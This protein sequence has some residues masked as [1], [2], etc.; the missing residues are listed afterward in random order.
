MVIIDNIPTGI[1]TS[2]IRVN[3]IGGDNAT[4]QSV[5][6][7][8]GESNSSDNPVRV[9]ILEAIDALRDQLTL[10]DDDLTA[11]A[12]QREFIGNLVDEGPAGFAQLLGGQ[13]G[14]IDQ[15]QTAWRAIGAGIAEVQAEIRRVMLE[16][17]DIE[18]EIEELLD[19]FTK[20]PSE[21]PHFEKNTL[22]GLKVRIALPLPHI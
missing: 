8:R 21:P 1:D 17:R 14:G 7:R 4:I 20:L 16:Q 12:A 6:V 15:W 9:Q 22:D 19:E 18:E 3:G 2:S 5:V 11:L 13:G 10:L